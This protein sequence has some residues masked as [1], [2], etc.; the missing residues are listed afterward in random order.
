MYYCF[1]IIFKKI[2]HL[3]NIF[4]TRLYFYWSSKF[5]FNSS[6]QPSYVVTIFIQFNLKFKL[7]YQEFLD[8]VY[9]AKY[10]NII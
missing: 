6:N 9:W 2:Y 8:L 10:N 5:F 7:D 4:K 1:N 3:E